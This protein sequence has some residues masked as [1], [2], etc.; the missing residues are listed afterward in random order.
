MLGT[1]ARLGAGNGAGRATGV[2]S[3]PFGRGLSARPKHRFA[4]RAGAAV[5]E[6][7]GEMIR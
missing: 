1:I 4:D 7:T 2:D 5:T 6:K 3:L